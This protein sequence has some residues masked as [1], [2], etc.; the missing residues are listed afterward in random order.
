MDDHKEGVDRAT[1]LQLLSILQRSRGAEAIQ[2]RGNRSSI[3]LMNILP[4]N[5]AGSSR[6]GAFKERGESSAKWTVV[7]MVKSLTGNAP[8]MRGMS[9]SG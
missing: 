4:S 8:G 1:C 9:I 5:S 6:R 2:G 3:Q 7:E